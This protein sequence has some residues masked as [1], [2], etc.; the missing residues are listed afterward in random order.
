MNAIVFES[1]IYT[2]SDSN[3]FTCATEVPWGAVNHLG[4]NSTTSSIHPIKNSGLSIIL[5]YGN[6]EVKG[7]GYLTLPR[8]DYRLSDTK[9]QLRIIKTGEPVSGFLIPAGEI[10]SLSA[11]TLKV[12]TIRLS[13]S[14]VV[15]TPSCSTADINVKM[16]QYKLDDFPKDGSPSDKIIPFSIKVDSCPGGINK[17]T[18]SLVPTSSAPAF[19]VNQG[20]INLNQRSTA[21]GI[22][23]QVMDSNLNPIILN[24]AK[25]LDNYSINGG[26]YTIPLNARYLKISN[27]SGIAPG[28][29]NSEMTFVMSYL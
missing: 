22:G 29:A 6:D 8:Q 7:H 24:K 25:T 16:G 23:L 21:K 20:I 19:N 18:Y 17:V 13:N 10:V 28:T 4:T 5:I 1:S 3:K 26:S 14:S 15:Y 9:M 2:N 12:S 27:G 11:G